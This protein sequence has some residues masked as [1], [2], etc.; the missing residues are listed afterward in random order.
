M[1][2]HTK[3]IPKLHAAVL[4]CFVLA[5]FVVLCLI[6]TETI[7]INMTKATPATERKRKQRARKKAKTSITTLSHMQSIDLKM[8]ER[9][10]EQRKRAHRDPLYQ[11]A[12][13]QEPEREYKPEL[14][15]YTHL[16]PMNIPCERGCGAVFFKDEVNGMKNTC[17]NS[18]GNGSFE[19]LQELP[20]FMKEFL[21]DPEFR[22][23][24]RNYNCAFQ[25]AH[26]GSTLE[27]VTK[28]DK[29]IFVHNGYP[30]YIRIHGQLYHS[31]P[32]VKPK[33]GTAARFVQIYVVD[34]ALEELCKNSENTDLD[35]KKMERILEYM[36]E[37]NPWARAIR[38]SVEQYMNNQENAPTVILDFVP[39]DGHKYRVPKDDI[40]AGFV[41]TGADGEFQ[42]FRHV[43]L[44]NGDGKFYSIS[45]LNVMY[46]PA[47]YVLMFLNG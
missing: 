1:P 10:N 14:D 21:D 24:I 40:I 28:R 32:P 13:L 38:R 5:I 33:Q 7:T 31:I 37:K 27:P 15:G 22:D 11:R 16:G 36:N 46:D 2:Y 39:N 47:H 8:K 23:K 20:D 35:K 34:N 4:I 45:E 42:K 25:I 9:F 19:T 44:N 43:Q 12:L 17:C 3:S 30:F 29:A 41:P 18:T 6:T 26:L